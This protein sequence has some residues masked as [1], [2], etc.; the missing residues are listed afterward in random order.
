MTRYRIVVV[1]AAATLALGVAAVVHASI[2]DGAGA[3]HA[4]YAKSA[5]PGSQ[6][7]S[8]RVI[9]TALGQSCQISEGSVSWSQTGPPGPQGPQGVQGLPGPKGDKGDKGDPGANAYF[10]GTGLNLSGGNTFN[11]QGSYRLPQGCATNQAPYQTAVPNA[12]GCFTAANAGESCSGGKFQNGI[13]ANGD[14]TC[15]TPAG[16]AG[17]EVWSTN[18]EGP[19]DTP[20]FG[21]TPIATLSL[22]A[23]T[24]VVDA[25]F[26]AGDDI[27]GD[28]EIK[29]TCLID[30]GGSSTALTGQEDDNDVPVSVHAVVVLAGAHDVGTRCSDFG[31]SDHVGYIEM[32]ALKVG[33]LH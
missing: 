26:S 7:G 18:V 20:Q 8:L 17:P 3:I 23:G 21:D 19:I 32:T 33:T 27:G 16:G 10:A 13:D 14:I 11:I 5:A 29:M 4:C 25:A 15:A 22:P 6:P 24:Y 9:D 28:G 2:P 12:W 1:A 31:G 30:P